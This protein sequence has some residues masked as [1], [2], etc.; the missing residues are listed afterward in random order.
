MYGK[1]ANLESIVSGHC[2]TFHKH[3]MSM[4]ISY[5]AIDLASQ[6]KL[7][8][9]PLILCFVYYFYSY[10]LQILLHT[11]Q[12]GWKNNKKLTLRP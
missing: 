2:T 7:T 8:K 10:T 3:V 4:G 9:F 6:M 11:L 12:K 5:L 1:V